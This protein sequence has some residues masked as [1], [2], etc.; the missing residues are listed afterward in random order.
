MN[1]L[2]VFIGSPCGL[3]LRNVLW[4]GFAS[5]QEIP[6]KYCSMMLLLTAGL[7]Q[8]LKSYLQHTEVTLEHRSFVT[9]KNLEDLIVFP[10]V[11]SEVLWVL[12]RVMMKSTFILK[13]MLPY[14]KF[15]LTKFTSHRFADCTILLL[16]QLEAGLRRVFAAV[17]QCPDRLLTAE[18]CVF[19]L[20]DV[21]AVL[22]VFCG[23]LKVLESI[24]PI[25]FVIQVYFLAKN[26]LWKP[27]LSFFC[28]FLLTVTFKQS[29]L[30]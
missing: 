1:V 9:L 22:A 7:G 12:E 5:P 8:L 18:V 24:Y 19:L 6:P 28:G 29:E 10:D 16:S 30:T 27:S 13:I 23:Q 26:F 20:R 17:N 2:K 4:H 25:V 21:V 15:A 14:W 11:T 3:N